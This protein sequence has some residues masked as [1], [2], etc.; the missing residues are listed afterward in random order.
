MCTTQAERRVRSF[1]ESGLTLIAKLIH[2]RD[3]QLWKNEEIQIWRFKHFQPILIQVTEAIS[4]G[5]FG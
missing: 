1:E 4:R 2:K 5:Y 3:L